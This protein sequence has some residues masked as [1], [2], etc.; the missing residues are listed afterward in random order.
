MRI[1]SLLLTVSDGHV[2]GR[3]AAAEHKAGAEDGTG[4]QKFCWVFIDHSSS[5]LGERQKDGY[6]F[7]LFRR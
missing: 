4:E 6:C 2:T 5:T 7:F 1:M 3:G